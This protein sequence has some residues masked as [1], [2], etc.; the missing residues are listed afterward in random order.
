MPGNSLSPFAESGGH[1]ELVGPI[2]SD[3]LDKLHRAAY[4][5]RTTLWQVNLRGYLLDTAQ[6]TP[7]EDAAAELA[8]EV[9]DAPA[10]Q[11]GALLGD[12][13]AQAQAAVR[14]ALAQQGDS[15]AIEL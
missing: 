4:K 11:D 13:I 3:E 5:A 14:E 10:A 8:P 15:P 7:Q 6:G 1:S 9:Q 2:A 12:R